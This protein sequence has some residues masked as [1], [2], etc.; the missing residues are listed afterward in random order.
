MYTISLLEKLL[1]KG[2]LILSNF[3]Y[4]IIDVEDGS[5][6]A[7][8]TVSWEYEELTLNRATFED[9][10][11]KTLL[12]RLEKGGYTDEESL[13]HLS[14]LYSNTDNLKKICGF[15]GENKKETRSSYQDGNF[16]AGTINLYTNNTLAIILD[17]FEHEK[18][19][20]TD[21]TPD[22]RYHLQKEIVKE[23]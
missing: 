19:Y 17:S 6:I 20:V 10:E 13:F 21:F 15:L 16:L 18:E 5:V 23:A 11:G 9:Y 2:I 4:S 8:D 3:T 7:T 22:Y 14:G 12:L 1:I